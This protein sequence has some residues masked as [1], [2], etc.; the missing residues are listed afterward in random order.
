MEVSM[1]M[2]LALLLVHPSLD[3]LGSAPAKV[4]QLAACVRHV[5]DPHGLLADGVYVHDQGYEGLYQ[6]AQ[7]I[8]DYARGFVAGTPATPNQA[9]RTQQDRVF[10]FFYV[11]N[12]G[13]RPEWQ[14]C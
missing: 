8:W 12:N 13:L 3:T 1:K 6:F 7:W 9:T 4:R 11:R 10:Y 14:E 5:E 2:L